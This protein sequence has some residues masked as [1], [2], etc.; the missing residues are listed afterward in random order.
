MDGIRQYA[1]SKLVMLREEADLYDVIGHF[2]RH[3]AHHRVVP[4]PLIRGF[5][6]LCDDDG[7]QAL[8]AHPHVHH[9]EDDIKVRL[10]GC[11]F[12]AK[13]QQRNRQLVPE[14]VQ[15]VRAPNAWAATQGEGVKVAIIDTGIDLSHPDLAS[16]IAGGVNFVT[17]GAPP[18]DDNGHGT[19]V[20]GTVAALNNTIGVVG[21]AP[22]ASL[23]AVKVLDSQ[24]SGNLSDIILGLQWA[25]D[26]KCHVAN[27]S[28]GTS[29]DAQSLRTA[30]RNGVA[31]GLTLV[32]AA[33]NNGTPNSVNYP[34][35]YPEVIAVSAVDN[36][37]HLAPFSSVGPEVDLAAP[38]VD[39]LSTLPRRRYGRLNG[40]S[41]ASPHVTGTAALYLSLHP[42]AMPGQVRTALQQAAAVLPG[43]S[44]DQ[45]GAGEVDARNLTAAQ[46]AVV[47][48]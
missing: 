12:Q 46:T 44:P 21:V 10:V 26:Q 2:H 11:L 25:V 18:Q 1:C 48:Q 34:A 23:Y 38:G 13:A 27:M 9:V 42:G 24:G 40:T 28:L 41:M 14:G 16:N 36:Q 32:A 43:L 4:V 19:H 47:E 3:G 35:R 31:A 45:Q 22:R 7:D 6:C 33:G 37:G 17:P 30:V 5:L 20:A 15:S 39:V 29:V 8:R